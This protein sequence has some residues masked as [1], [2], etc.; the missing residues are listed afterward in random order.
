MNEKFDKLIRKFKE[1]DSIVEAISY[2][3]WNNSFAE[4][5][6]K[7]LSIVSLINSE[8]SSKVLW[9][10]FWNDKDIWYSNDNLNDY[11]TEWNKIENPHRKYYWE[12]RKSYDE[13]I[14]S[15]RLLFN[16]THLS[17][18]VFLLTL[19]KN[20]NTIFNSFYIDQNEIITDSDK[21]LEEYYKNTLAKWADKKDIIRSITIANS[22]N[23]DEITYKYKFLNWIT[24]I[25]NSYLDWTDS[26]Y[27]DSKLYYS[28]SFENYSDKKDI[29]ESL[30][31][32]LIFCNVGIQINNNEDV[33]IETFI[34][35]LRNVL[36]KI[37]FIREKIEYEKIIRKS[38]IKSAIAA[39]MSR[40]MSHNLGSHVITNTKN[41]IVGIAENSD[42]EQAKD[43]LGLSSLLHYIQERQDFIAVVTGDEEYAKT[44]INFKAHIFDMLAYDGPAIR[45]KTSTTP[46]QTN[47]ILD[48]I[49]KS[50]NYDRNNLELILEIPTEISNSDC[51]ENYCRL[52]SKQKNPHSDDFNNIYLSIPYGINGRQGFLSILENF[53]RNSAKHDKIEKIKN[54]EFTIRI[55]DDIED[56]NKKLI[57]IYDNKLNAE[58]VIKKLKD[59][60]L[61]SNEGKFI[62]NQLSITEES[63]H[64]FKGIKEMLICVAWLQGTHQYTEALAKPQDFLQIVNIDKNF[65]ISFTL[66][67]HLLVKDVDNESE[68][69]KKSADIYYTKNELDNNK[70]N[71]PRLVKVDRDFSN[72]LEDFETLYKIYF[73]SKFGDISDYKIYIIDNN[74]IPE[75]ANSTFRFISNGE[76]VEND[77][78]KKSL[79]DN[80]LIDTIAKKHIIFKNHYETFGKDKNFEK[81]EEN[82]YLEGIS[83]ANYTHSLLRNGMFDEIKA[84]RIIESCLT[85]ILIVDE[86]L[87][88]KYKSDKNYKHMPFTDEIIEKIFEKKNDYFENGTNFSYRKF[89]NVCDDI[90]GYNV[91][92]NF[93]YK[94]DELLKDYLSNFEYTTKKTPKNW[95]DYFYGKN[96]GI[97]NYNLST[98]KIEYIAEDQ[99]KYDFISIHYGLIEKFLETK[100]NENNIDTI[101]KALASFISLIKT[102]DNSFISIHS[103]RG[104]LHKFKENGVNNVTFI[105]LSG[106]EWAVE[107]CKFT[108]TELF[109]SEI[110][111]PINT[112]N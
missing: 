2:E 103:G 8:F 34:Y 95:G 108:T 27:L 86:R 85:N 72:T 61:L 28:N 46:Q 51:N 54:L 82:Y 111:H 70:K 5:L 96:I 58:S 60:R 93:N 78:I 101:N 17:N 45:H 30:S 79:K 43:L 14:A 89:S 56:A 25:K 59:K 69:Q 18:E 33:L 75:D 112:T 36:N 19:R 10:N 80:E 3:N 15:S 110:Y 41:Y 99:K 92:L 55:E 84:M 22:E 32:A 71:Y 50:E 31:E 11:I 97:A 49:V 91:S 107:N 98:E 38:Q 57:T 63:K 23:G 90:L 88:E 102:T 6:D 1:V 20:P 39:I 81:V 53:V 77:S 100:K 21:K 35:R 9:I 65:G 109:Y 64:E 26:Y 73:K 7:I 94:N 67:K 76:I 40:N 13:N 104:D 83:G 16:N 44:G 42:T 105:P 24:W 87:F 66:D 106:L 37:R 4:I 52:K 74:A 62:E 12:N 29:E 47:Y 48:N 68:N